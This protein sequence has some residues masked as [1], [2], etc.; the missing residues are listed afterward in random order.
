MKFENWDIRG[1]NRDAAVELCR[2]GLNP[3]VSVFLASRG[4][5]RIND[6]RTFLKAGVGLHDPFLLK[7]MDKAV[8]A[9]NSAVAGK[10]KIAVYGDYDVDGMTSCALLSLWLRSKGA[11]FEV[12]IPGRFEEGYGLNFSAAD[13]LHKRGIGLIIT[14]DCGVTAIA[15][16]EHAKKLGMDLVITDHHECREFLPAAAA[17]VNPKRADC[18]YPNKDLAGV[19]VVFKL[20]CALEHGTDEK[21]LL[22]K[23]AQ[24]VAVGTIADVMSVVGENRELLKYGLNSLNSNPLVGLSKLMQNGDNNNGKID[25]VTIGFSIA[26]KLNAAGR[27]GVPELSVSLLLT[28]DEREAEELAG[29]L[30][31]LNLNRRA[32]E[33]QIHEE[34]ELMLPKSVF[35]D[36]PSGPII[37]AKRGWYQ[38]V[39][40]IVAARMAERYRAPAVIITIDDDGVGR[41]SCRSYGSFN[42]FEAIHSCADILENYGGHEKAAGVTV[43]EKHINELGRRIAEFYAKTISNTPKATLKLDFEVEKPEL[44]TIRNLEALDDLKPFGN[45]NLPPCLCIKG[46]EVVSAF[47]IGLGKHTK[48]RIKKKA[49][50]FDAICFSLPPEQLG[51]G[52]GDTADIAFEPHIN[53]YRGADNVQLQVID[54]R[55]S[56]NQL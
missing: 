11:D 42:I 2:E 54:I 22:E 40:G 27:M 47:A 15:E 6:A 28:L 55:K 49:V 19:G 51:V 23:Y 52:E 53:S 46:A 17:V 35:K 20:I 25:T 10:K 32:L 12:Y 13:A 14:V 1:F 38:G 50:F 39:A 26:P 34:A 37:L 48:L 16:A 8:E 36:P 56:D 43:A 45:G 9:I 7:D 3:L 30:T 33:S 5:E 29:R 18:F 44:L 4:F 21:T 41:G 24:L 31:E